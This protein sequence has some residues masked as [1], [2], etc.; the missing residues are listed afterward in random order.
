A[1]D[2]C[3]ES[4]AYLIPAEVRY[5]PNCRVGDLETVGR[6][7][8]AEPDAEALAT[9]LRH[10]VSHPE[11]A[12]A[13]GAAGSAFVR[14][15]LTWEHAAEAVERRLHALRGQPIRRFSRTVVPAGPRRMRV[16]LCMIVKNEE[17][18]LADCLASAADL[19]DEIVIVD[20]GSTDR[21]KEIPAPLGARGFDLP[22]VDSFPPPPH[23]SRRPA[24]AHSPLSRG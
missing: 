5:F 9:I 20:T 3:D 16:S 2:Y 22:W 18:N 15:N 21:T 6:P 10:V 4:R 14:G 19:V 23:R 13:K 24:P 8:L 1:L 11:E 7:W 12:K 17:H